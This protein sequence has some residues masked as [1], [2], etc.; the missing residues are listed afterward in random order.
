[1]TTPS[2]SDPAVRLFA[3]HRRWF[4]QNRYV[5]PVVSRR[6]GGL[7][8]GVNLNP[9]KRCIFH[10]VY[11]QVDRNVPGEQAIVDIDVLR[12]ELDAALQLALSGGIFALPGF[13]DT[14]EPLR[15]VCDIALSG[16]GEPTAFANFEAVVELC[17]RVRG[18]SGADALK[19][20]L[21]TN[22]G[23]LH[24]DDVRRGLAI[25]DAHNG[26]IWG[27]L[28]AG[29]EDY[30]RQ[31]ARTSIPL[32]RILD[33]LLEAAQAR[34]IVLQSLFLR[35]HGVPTPD[36]EQEA[37]CDRLNAMLAAGGAIKRVQ[38]HTVARPPAEPWVEPLGDAELDALADRVRRRTGLPV[39]THYGI[40]RPW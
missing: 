12:A 34:P 38:V 11:C 2:P 17:A 1:M 7:S 32:R 9:D 28:D 26:E 16:D 15:R 25:L 39:T 23:L 27:K 10:C 4:G 33:N 37:Y 14:P 31:V 13:C 8:I 29:T 5:Y 40:P 18:Q 19:I 35:L 30:F 24:R 6:A 20:V 22:A 36:A 3:S 21:I